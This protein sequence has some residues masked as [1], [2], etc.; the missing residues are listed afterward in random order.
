MDLLKRTAKFETVILN[1]RGEIV[2][3]NPL[4]TIEQVQMLPG[5]VELP[6]INIPAG[7]FD[8]GS[9]PH[10]GEPEEF[11]RHNVLVKS[12]YMSKYPVT[13]GQSSGKQ[14]FME[15]RKG[16]LQGI[17]GIHRQAISTASRIGM[18]ICVQGVYRGGPTDKDQ[19]PPNRYGLHDMHGNVWEWCEDTWHDNYEGAPLD[20]KTWTGGD[21]SWHVMRG[22][23]WHDPP[24]L[25]RSAMRLRAHAEEGEGYFGFRVA[26]I[27][28]GLEQGTSVC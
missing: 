4:E 25:C 9:L 21:S 24:G 27:F 2:E 11:P 26:V 17:G 1:K 8:M 22:G 12:F 5:N 20:N 13:Q 14:N 19:F 3:K 7:V 15:C 28:G 10:K 16:F 6:L 23:S 18:G